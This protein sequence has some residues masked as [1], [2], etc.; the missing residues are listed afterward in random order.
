MN[1]LNDVISDY[2][3]ISLSE[4]DSVSL[5]NRIDTKYLLPMGDALKILASLKGD[6]TVLDI[7]GNRL[8]EYLTTYF[9]TDDKKLLYDHLRGKLN[10]EKV[11]TR[12]YVGTRS[13]FFEMKL[14]TNKG[15]TVK[16]RIPKKGEMDSIQPEESEFL[17]SVSKLEANSLNPALEVKFNR[18]TLVNLGQKERMTFDFNLAF[19]SGETLKGVDDLVIIELKRDSEGAHRTKA[20]ELL[21]E[22]SAR[23][24]SMSKYCLGMILL[25]KAERYNAYKPKLLNLNKLSAHGDIW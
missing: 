9:D 4:M 18:I 17:S 1:L 11:R 20:M 3:P 2:E 8:F 15:R 5:M 16:K 13:R 23:P 22:I 24:S 14:K 25:N 10:R 7:E 6:Y 21:K 19:G 12:E